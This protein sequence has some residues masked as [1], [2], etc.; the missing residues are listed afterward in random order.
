MLFGAHDAPIDRASHGRLETVALD[1]RQKLGE[2]SLVHPVDPLTLRAR[3]RHEIEEVDDRSGGLTRVHDERVSFRKPA[4]R[5]LPALAFY[6]F[7]LDR[8]ALFGDVEE[9]FEQEPAL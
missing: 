8:A 9:R 2:E 3:R 7:R 4:H 1:A 6:L 5:D